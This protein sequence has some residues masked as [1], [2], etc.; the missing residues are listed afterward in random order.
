MFILYSGLNYLFKKKN[1]DPIIFV[2]IVKLFKLYKLYLSE[3][4]VFKVT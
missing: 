2:I 4:K 1:T 3:K